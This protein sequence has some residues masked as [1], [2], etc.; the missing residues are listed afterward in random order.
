MFEIVNKDQNCWSKE[1]SWEW[2]RKKPYIIGCNFLPSTAVNST[3]MWA[4]ETFDA[5]TIE[6]ELRWAQ[7]IGYNNIRVFI[8]YILFE[9]E[10]EE[11]FQN[12]KKLLEI[13]SNLNISVTPVLFDDCAF[14]DLEPYLGKQNEPKYLVHNSGWTPS[15]GKQL[16]DDFTKYHLLKNYVKE[17]IEEFKDDTRILMWDL[18]NEPGNSKRGAKSLYLLEKAFEWARQINPTQPLTA[19]VWGFE[20]GEI[21]PSTLFVD[22]K[23]LELSDVITIHHYGNEDQV[24]L[25]LKHY[26]ELGY[27]IICTE[28]MARVH[29]SSYIEEILP[30]F[31]KKGVGAFNWGL[32]NGKTQTH[33][34]W[35]YDKS[36]GE[37][38]TWFHDI[39]HKD[40]TPYNKEELLVIKNISKKSRSEGNE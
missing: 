1:K 26:G 7:N 3:E 4:K 6:K 33:I 18:Y 27:P 14:S 40:G 15:P 29:L 2:Y 34:P 37:P 11:L 39:L 10:K 21:E 12:I 31:Y 22:L 8:Q 25:S 19:G 9:S 36:L 20:N 35:N 23:S 16:T 5:E 32:V 28:W 13:A 38:K 24:E 30:L 17:V